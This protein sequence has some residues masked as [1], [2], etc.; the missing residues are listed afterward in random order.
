MTAPLSLS[1]ASRV[2]EGRPNHCGTVTWPMDNKKSIGNHR[3]RRK[4]I[5]I[6]YPRIQVSVVWC[7]SPRGWGGTVIWCSPPPPLGVGGNCRSR[8]GGGVDMGRGGV[9]LD[10]SEP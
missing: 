9:A 2:E 5:L 6:R 10:S 3:R 8:A 7:P 1:G 4:I